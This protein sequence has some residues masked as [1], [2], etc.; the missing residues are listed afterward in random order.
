MTHIDKYKTP[1]YFQKYISSQTI[2]I[3]KFKQVLIGCGESEKSKIYR[4]LS[5]RYKDLISA[6]FSCNED[7]IKIK[8]S[9]VEYA[10]CVYAAGYSCYS[11]YIDFL[12]LQIILG[13]K[14]VSI[15]APKE[16]DDDLSR[17]LNAYIH[18]SNYELTGYLYETRY[19]SVFADYCKGSLTFAEL[20]DYVTNKWYLSSLGFYWFDSHLKDFDVYTGY[21]CYIASAVIRIKGDYGKVRDGDCYIV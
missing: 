6:Q 2:R 1:D 12:S 15:E 16:Y 19:Y 3:E 20:M 7:I 5:D 11:E 14:D 9:F 8:A 21:W 17:I 10:E 13:I 18:D 4:I